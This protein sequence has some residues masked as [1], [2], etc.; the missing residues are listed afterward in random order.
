MFEGFFFTYFVNIDLILKKQIKMK[1]IL[2]SIHEEL[3]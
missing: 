2:G 3:N 1:K